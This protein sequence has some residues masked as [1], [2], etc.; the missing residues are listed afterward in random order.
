MVC[1]KDEKARLFWWE[2]SK[3]PISN[4]FPLLIIN[5]EHTMISNSTVP[6]LLGF[7]FFFLQTNQRRNCVFVPFGHSLCL[8]GPIQITFDLVL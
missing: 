7:W 3:T 8:K 4:S 1:R 5:D 6:F 2:A